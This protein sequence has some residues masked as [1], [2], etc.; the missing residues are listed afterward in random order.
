LVYFLMT[1]MT[2]DHW[3]ACVFFF[4]FS[5]TDQ[6]FPAKHQSSLPSSKLRNINSDGNPWV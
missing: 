6:H 2:I 1:I 3:P 4:I 5:T